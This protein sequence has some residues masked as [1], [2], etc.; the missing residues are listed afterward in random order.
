MD[1]FLAIASHDLRTPLT[2]VKTR[3]QIALRRLTRRL[4][5]A[6]APPD[7]LSETDLE[8]L[9]ASLLAANQSADKLTRLVSLLLDVSRARSGTLELQLAPCDLAAL[10]R[11]QVTAQQMVARDRTIELVVPNAPVVRALA[12]ADRLSQVLGNYLNNALKYSPADQPVTVRLEKIENQA[13]VSV[14]DH[15]PGLPPEEQSRIWDWF[16]RV[17][18]IEVQYV[19]GDS[20][21]SLGLGLHICKQL[22]ELHHGGG[23]GVESV[24]GKGST[25]WFRLPLTS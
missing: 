24:V 8:A 6:A 17:P 25:F 14:A 3:V 5:D 12:D 18:G 13:V 23:V 15:G 1:E 9:Y 22:V 21:G 11:E 2:V 19:S 4:D 7:A 16:H 20:A 10:V